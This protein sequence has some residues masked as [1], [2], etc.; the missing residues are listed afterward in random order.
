MPITNANIEKMLILAAKAG[1]MDLDD[2]VKTIYQ[3]DSLVLPKM[4][5][6]RAK[7]LLGAKPIVPVK[8]KSVWAR[9]STKEYATDLGLSEADITERTGKDGTIVLAD[10][11]TAFKAKK[12]ADRIEKPKKEKKE[13]QPAKPAVVEVKPAISEPVFQDGPERVT[14]DEG[15]EFEDEE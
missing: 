2:L 1:N 3:Q 14:A 13:K 12:L 11:K 15:D 5:Q 10:V 4:F 8:E 6:E 7:E 9:K